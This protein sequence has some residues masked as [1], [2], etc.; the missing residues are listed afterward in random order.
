MSVLKMNNEALF[1]RLL[2][3]KRVVRQQF[4]GAASAKGDKKKSW[5]PKDGVRRV[6]HE[7]PDGQSF[8]LIHLILITDHN[9]VLGVCM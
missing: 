5:L 2:G 8:V 1:S 7:K 9:L 6:N 3:Y 4:A